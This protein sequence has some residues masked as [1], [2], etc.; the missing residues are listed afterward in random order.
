MNALRPGYQESE[1]QRGVVVDGA[2]ILLAFQSDDWRVQCIALLVV[3]AINVSY[4]I[5]RSRQKEA[6]IVAQAEERIG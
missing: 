1:F 3:G 4:N 2:G 5:N 6:A